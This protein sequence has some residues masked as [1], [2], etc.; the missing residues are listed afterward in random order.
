[1][2]GL[3][4][5]INCR[6]VRDSQANVL[7]GVLSQP[8]FGAILAAEAAL[9]VAIVELGGRAFSTVP[10]SATQWAACI[11]MGAT[12]LLVRAGLRLVPVGS[13]GGG[14]RVGARA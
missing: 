10:L 4:P 6:R 7:E 5:Q 13:G 9:Q 11:A 14:G 1:M 3:D 2:I 12:S 8:Q